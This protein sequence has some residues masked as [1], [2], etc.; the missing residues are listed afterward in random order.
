MAGKR[1]REGREIPPSGPTRS[2]IITKPRFGV[3]AELHSMGHDHVR[4]RQRRRNEVFSVETVCT[5]GDIDRPLPDRAECVELI[6]Y[7]AT[8][9]PF[10]VFTFVPLWITEMRILRALDLSGTAISELPPEIGHLAGLELLSL[11]RTN[12]R[13]LPTE[14]SRLCLLQ[15]LDLHDCPHLTSLPTSLCDL[16]K[17]LELLNLSHT[18]TSALLIP[19]GSDWG[20]VSYILTM[21]HQMERATMRKVVL[22]LLMNARTPDPTCPISYLPRPLIRMLLS[23]LYVPPVRPYALDNSAVKLP[24]VQ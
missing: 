12:L 13:T 3:S 23:W 5:D 15:W 20:D 18:G 19:D 4:F 9:A 16:W 14:V 8:S 11:Y 24:A 10:P 2:R 7:D 21:L 17:S 1:D 6:V 22:L